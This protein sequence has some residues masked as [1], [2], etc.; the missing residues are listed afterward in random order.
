MIDCPVHQGKECS[1]SLEYRLL[2]A[3][4]QLPSYGL[5]GGDK[6]NPMISRKEIESL[7]SRNQ[8]S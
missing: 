6:N 5:I 1:C 3:V 2:S 4:R 7:L 8:Q